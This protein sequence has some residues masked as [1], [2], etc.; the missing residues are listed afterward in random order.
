MWSSSEQGHSIAAEGSRLVSA[1]VLARAGSEQVAQAYAQV[2]QCLWREFAGKLFFKDDVGKGCCTESE[3][4]R[5]LQ[6]S[7]AHR[8]RVHK[9]WRVISQTRFL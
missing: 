2:V 3:V 8:G 6:R 1:L 7:G 9:V 4:Q 5:L